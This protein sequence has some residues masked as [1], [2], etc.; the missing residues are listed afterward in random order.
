MKCRLL[1]ASLSV[2]LALAGCSA[3]PQQDFVPAEDDGP[4]YVETESTPEAPP[5]TLSELACDFL[6]G[7]EIADAYLVGDLGPAVEGDQDWNCRYWWDLPPGSW[8]V[9]LGVRAND[10]PS[11]VGSFGFHVFAFTDG[12][13]VNYAADA[14]LPVRSVSDLLG[15][16]RDYF[17]NGAWNKNNSHEYTEPGLGGFCIDNSYCH[18]ALNDKYFANLIHS[19]ANNAATEAALIRLAERLIPD[20]EALG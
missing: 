4:A 18:I 10:K 13:E 2:T 17:F 3:A 16:A 19:N 5:P 6:T 8:E 7:Q 15:P 20:V 1:I 11:G 12:H 14:A 9:V